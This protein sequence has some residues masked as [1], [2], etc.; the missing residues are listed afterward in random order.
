MRQFLIHFATFAVLFAALRY[1]TG[2][3]DIGP[4]ALQSLITALFFAVG[5][6]I[7]SATRRNTK[8]RK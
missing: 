3:T 4:L 2:D 1:V 5:M 6:G 7:W 8:D